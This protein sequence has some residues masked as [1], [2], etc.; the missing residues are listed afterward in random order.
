MAAAAI[1][2]LF[3]PEIAPFDPRS[4][5]VVGLHQSSDQEYL[6]RYFSY[7]APPQGPLAITYVCL[8]YTSDAADE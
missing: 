5:K 3:E 6:T 8:L 1:L 2:D 4:P 7:I